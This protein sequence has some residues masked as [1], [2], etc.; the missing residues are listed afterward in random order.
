MLKVFGY[1]NLAGLNIPL[2]SIIVL[3][4]AA[5]GLTYLFFFAEK[6][7]FYPA[8]PFIT[9]GILVGIG[10]SWLVY[11]KILGIPIN[12]GFLF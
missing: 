9:A 3:L 12:F 7:K 2:A 10:V 8:M 11:S 6:K 5:F 1:V 4:G